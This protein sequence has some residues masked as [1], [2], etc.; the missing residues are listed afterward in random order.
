MNTVLLICIWALFGNEVLN[1]RKYF[2]D[3]RVRKTR[4]AYE[5]FFRAMSTRNA[6]LRSESPAYT[7]A[8][9]QREG[10]ELAEGAH[11]HDAPVKLKT[12]TL[13]RAEG[14]YLTVREEGVLDEQKVARVMTIY[15]GKGRMAR[16]FIEEAKRTGRKMP[17]G[18]ALELLDPSDLAN[19][20]P[21]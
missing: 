8:Q 3:R 11:P 15:D 21:V 12:V 5:K 10:Q 17:E 2:G 6:E 14:P 13:L 18:I 1:L 16:V 4:E 7:E 19:R 9:A 20:H